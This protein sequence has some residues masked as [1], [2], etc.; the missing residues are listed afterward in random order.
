MTDRRSIFGALVVA[1]AFLSPATRAA[2]PPRISHLTDVAVIN[3]RNKDLIAGYAEYWCRQLRDPDPELIEE[4][5]DKLIEP[6]RAVQVREAFRVEYTRAA[7]P[8][9]GDVVEKGELQSRVNAMQ[10][11]AWLGTPRALEVILD[12]A[13]AENQPDFATRLWAALSFPVAV[14]QGT[15]PQ[16]EINQAL[17]KFGK[18]AKEEKSWLILRR[19]FEAIAWVES[20]VSREL[21]VEILK[22]T[23]R[24]MAA[25]NPG[26]SDLISAT[27]PALK[28]IRDEY[29]QLVDR[30]DEQKPFGKELAPVLCDVCSVANAHWEQA[31]EN[32]AAKNEYGGAIH[33]AE[34][35]LRLIDPDQ[36]PG[37][38]TPQTQ[39]GPAWKKSDQPRFIADHHKWQAVLS[40]PPYNP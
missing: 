25:N 1:L 27:Y 3:Q 15:L 34:N 4:A 30:P 37:A 18:A 26:P 36:R 11:V 23:T 29:L 33:I 24:R 7:L 9:L 14:D 40:A 6:L 35:L 38:R 13:N 10:V 5:Q 32:S 39:L 22:S 21:Q 28:L 2:P 20:P 16:N 31:Q 19:Q 17:R 12:H 8:C